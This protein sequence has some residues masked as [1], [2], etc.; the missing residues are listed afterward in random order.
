[1]ST[2][3]D[4]VSAL[5]WPCVTVW[6]VL[7][8]GEE[9]K[10]LIYRLSRM[11]MA[12]VEAEFRASLEEVEDLADEVPNVTLT[13]EAQNVDPEFTRRLSQLQR[14]ANISPR[15]AIMESWL[16]IEE[17]AG[18]A[19]FVQGASIP[20]INIGLFIDWLVKDGK[21]SST[22]AELVSKMR[23]LRNKAAHLG[24]FEL[25]KD[26]A[27]RYLNIAVQISTLIINSEDNLENN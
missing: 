7:R 23:L 25:T 1:M 10:Q 26:E 16:L 15:A 20:R 24:D 14:I 27:E 5:A 19:G 21:I 18:K 22:T 17:A 12:G 2:L 6:F 11:K 3:V 8:F 13:P 9:V 4:L